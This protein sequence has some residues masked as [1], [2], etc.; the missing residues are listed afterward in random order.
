M[1][2]W[3]PKGG[4]GLTPAEEQLKCY[5]KRY[6]ANKD[7]RLR[8]NELKLAFQNL[9]LNFSGFRAKRALRHADVNEDG[10]IDDVEMNELVIYASKWGLSNRIVG[11][12]RNSSK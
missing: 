2:I 7:G 9:E 5:L 1:P 12:T 8:R 6:A 10:Y 11:E 3:V 4:M